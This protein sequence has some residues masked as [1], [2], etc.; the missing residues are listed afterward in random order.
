MPG[1]PGEPAGRPDRPAVGVVVAAHQA[2]RHLGETLASL[3]AQTFGAWACV[4]VDDGSSDATGEVAEAVAS[5]D[6]RVRVLHQPNGGVS[7]ARNAGLAALPDGAE[8][9]LFLDSDDLLLPDALDVLVA[10]LR[11]RPD[12]V[13]VSAWAELVDERGVPYAPGAHPRAQRTRRVHRGRRTVLLDPGED[14]TFASLAIH[15]A[16]W[17]P[18]TA[19]TRCSVARTSGGFDPALS[20]QE[21]WDFFLRASRLGPYAFVDRQVAW[22][23]RHPGNA[24]RDLGRYLRNSAV[25]RRKAWVDPSNTRAQRVT[26]LRANARTLA[27]IVRRQADLVPAEVRDGDVAAAALGLAWVVYGLAALA[28][29]V[30]VVP[31][32]RV[33]AALAGAE[34]RLRTDRGRPAYL[35]SY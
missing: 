29:V 2:E 14:S 21:D 17:P 25:V 16:I 1:V 7:A 9:V 28:C 4:V 31:P 3:R 12:A 19:L 22:Y 8:Y 6:P 15:G 35:E 10:A 26:L 5:A 20:A 24:T 11:R 34:A 32:R 18:A 27:W 30:P 23:R 13:G 33:V